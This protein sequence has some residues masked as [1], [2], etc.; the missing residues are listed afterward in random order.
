MIRI[1][2]FLFVLCLFAE[3]TELIPLHEL[4]NA[5]NLSRSAPKHKLFLNSQI[6]TYNLTLSPQSMKNNWEITPQYH[7]SVQNLGICPSETCK[8]VMNLTLRNFNNETSS[9]WDQVSLKSFA[10]KPAILNATN[11]VGFAIKI[12][13]W[14]D[15][16]STPVTDDFVRRS[17]TER[18][19]LVYMNSTEVRQINAS[20]SE[21][22]QLCKNDNCQPNLELQSH[23]IAIA[24]LNND[25]LLDLINYRTSYNLNHTNWLSSK[26]QIVKLDSFL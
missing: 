1:Q 12:W 10:S 21:V 11:V 5:V 19:I 20:Q 3:I 9:V 23:S 16:N 6:N 15:M 8:V 13:E 2:R 7:L 14:A 25:G 18:V 4:I 24:D 17:W 22:L 26:V